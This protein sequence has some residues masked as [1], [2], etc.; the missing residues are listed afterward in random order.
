MPAKK[1]DEKKVM[2]VSSPGESKPDTGSKPM[3][4]GHKFLSSDPDVKTK[5]AEETK[6]DDSNKS[7]E[8]ETITPKKKIVL[9]PLSDNIKTDEEEPDET[10]MPEEKDDKQDSP[11]ESEVSSKEDEPKQEEKK[12]EPKEVSEAEKSDDQQS[13]NDASEETQKDEDKAN[14]EKENRLQDI[15]KSK[16]YYVPIKHQGA[17]AVKTFLVTFILVCV[18]GLLALAILIDAEV[19][20]FGIDLPFD[21]L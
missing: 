17:S 16:E 10:K 6:E 9:K 14:L 18:V 7:E 3:V 21:F 4:V 1:E 13:D 2:D 12:E 19:L 11:N 5:D 8:K 20:D 15:I